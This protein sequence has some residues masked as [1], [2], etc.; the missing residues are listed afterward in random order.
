[1]NIYS[2]KQNYN[3]IIQKKG[4]IT[5]NVYKK[6]TCNN[7]SASIIILVIESLS[8]KSSGSNETSLNSSTN[9]FKAIH[10]F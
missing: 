2:N 8:S 6:A 5:E 10:N 9:S 7:W 4:K 3:Y 1:M